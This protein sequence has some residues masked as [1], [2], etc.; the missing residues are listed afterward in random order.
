[1][2]GKSH[3]KSRA[4]VTSSKPNSNLNSRAHLSEDNLNFVR[5]LL[6]SGNTESTKRVYRCHLNYFWSWAQEVFGIEEH[7]PVKLDVV[8]KFIAD[9][10]G[11]MDSKVEKRLIERGIKGHP[12]PLSLSTCWHPSNSDPGFSF[13]TDP[14]FLASLM[15]P[16]CG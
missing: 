5:A 3:S 9:N 7:Y 10:L 4:L 6:E 11:S 1:M 15:L 13:K 16:A 2:A 14:P 12:G 8:L